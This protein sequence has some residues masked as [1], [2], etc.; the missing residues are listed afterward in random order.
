MKP[1]PRSA[2][3]KNIV[4]ID[5]QMVVDPKSAQQW[6]A[7]SASQLD[8]WLAACVAAE[9][10]Q[11]VVV[12][13]RIVDLAEMT[14]LNQAYRNKSG[15]T[16]VLSFPCDL[17]Q[18]LAQDFIGDI[19]IC[20]PVVARE[21]TEQGKPPLAHWCHMVVHGVLHLFGYDHEDDAHAN[22]MEQNERSILTALGFADPYGDDPTVQAAVS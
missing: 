9:N 12:T 6:H 7:P 13:V 17:P 14:Q 16:N 11:H 19:I 4:D 3:S 18:E 21:A 20:A 10:R 5:L 8:D 1:R 15:P 22:I 2:K